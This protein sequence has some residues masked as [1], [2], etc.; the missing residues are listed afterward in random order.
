[1]K[2]VWLRGRGHCVMNVRKGERL[3]RMGA[4]NMY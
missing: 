1:M 4:K 3:K 2:G